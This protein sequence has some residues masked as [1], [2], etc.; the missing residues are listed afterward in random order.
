MIC[1]I[2]VYF[3]PAGGEYV[4]AEIAQAE[5]GSPDSQDAFIEQPDYQARRMGILVCGIICCFRSLISSGLETASA[6]IL[7]T[8]FAWTK[9]LVGIGIGLSFMLTIPGRAAFMYLKDR[10]T[11]VEHL[12]F[13]MV[14]CFFASIFLFKTADNVFTVGHGGV[15]TLLLSSGSILYCAIYQLSGLIEGIMTTFALP[16][17]SFF[18]VDNVI[19]FKLIMMDSIGRAIGPPLARMQVDAGGKE[20][21]QDCYAWQQVAMTL[22]TILLTEAVLFRSMDTIQEFGKKRSN[23]FDSCGGAS[24]MPLTTGEAV[25]SKTALAPALSA[26][27]EHTKSA[28]GNA[29]SPADDTDG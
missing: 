15:P 29:N 12:R 4:Q 16:V 26:I 5:T 10:L 7:E 3:V 11:L 24:E 13:N 1:L 17:G 14:A 23:S 20:N 25:A 28:E 21:G 19:L 18:T 27:P 2:A 6:M 8:D 9:N 22:T